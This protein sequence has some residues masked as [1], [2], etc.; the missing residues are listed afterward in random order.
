VD[1]SNDGNEGILIPGS[2]EESGFGQV[3][4]EIAPRDGGTVRARAG[5]LE[6]VE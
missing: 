4:A 6:R 3:Y 5:D 1:G 2:I